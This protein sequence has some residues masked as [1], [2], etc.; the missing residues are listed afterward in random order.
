[1][2]WLLLVAMAACQTPY[3]PP[4]TVGASLTLSSAFVQQLRWSGTQVRGI[5]YD[6][7][8]VNGGE[9]DDSG[10]QVTSLHAVRPRSS[11]TLSAGPGASGSL[12]LVDEL[13]L[14]TG[15]ALVAI[16]PVQTATVVGHSELT[17]TALAPE[18]TPRVLFSC[19]ACRY[20]AS[21][22]VV[23]SHILVMV[24]SED[25]PRLIV[26]TAQG[27]IER[28]FTTAFSP[29]AQ[30]ASARSDA[31]TV[32]DTHGFWLL[33]EAGDTIAGPLPRNGDVIDW[34]L[35]RGLAAI[36]S[37][38]TPLGAAE[39]YLA[40]SDFSGAGPV[41]HLSA[42]ELIATTLG[43]E[44]SAA[45]F[46]DTGLYF[47]AMRADGHKLGGD[48]ALLPASVRDAP[49]TSRFTTQALV[50]EVASHD[51]LTVVARPNGTQQQHVVCT[52]GA[53]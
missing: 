52:P 37:T 11:G 32:N 14:F 18:G 34:D 31:L 23:G 9:W 51:F 30:T 43:E 27:E 15:T 21:A 24:N 47:A 45:L 49:A 7:N 44:L 22:Q 6:D 3:H 19:D 5:W 29:G 53:P 35:R 4:C 25:A 28:S 10:T 40:R 8:G 39:V 48:V 1:M 33:N 46:V 38:R 42:G 41:R 26:V 17:L 20:T 36:G 16:S 50:R 2:R 12:S 13:D